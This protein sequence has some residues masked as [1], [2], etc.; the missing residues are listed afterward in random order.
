[1]KK[2]ALSLAFLLSLCSSAAQA[3][4][5]IHIDI[6]LPEIPPLV[7]VQPGIQVVEGFQE[8]VFFHRGWYWCRRPDGWYRAHS[9]RERFD[10]IEA[11]RV[12]HSL[13]RM[14]EGHYRNWHHDE[15]RGRPD[16]R[17]NLGHEPPKR[18]H[19]RPGPGYEQQEPGHEGKDAEHDR[20]HSN[21]G[22]RKRRLLP[23]DTP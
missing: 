16:E 4:V 23:P 15:G 5:N 22:K 12:P 8:E 13:V 21:K 2:T 17:P 11:N 3:Q 14:P 18:G 19:K 7:E 9:P 6:G 10:R 1:M 20:E